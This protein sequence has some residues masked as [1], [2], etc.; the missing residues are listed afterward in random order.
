MTT[1]TTIGIGSQV[2]HIH[3]DAILIEDNIRESVHLDDGFV[4]SIREHGVIQPVLAVRNPD[5][6][7]SVRD[8]QRRTLGARA[9]GVQS[10]PAYVV[11]AGD[12]RALRIIQQIIANDQ[13]TAITEAERVQ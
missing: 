11:A 8:G 5:G 9:A 6:T 4:A 1:T 10:I 3:P 12:D 13:R 2:E 7:L